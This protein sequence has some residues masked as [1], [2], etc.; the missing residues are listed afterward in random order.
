MG[1]QQLLLLVLGIV[2]VAVA[3]VGGLYIFDENIKKNNAE[4]LVS[5]AINIATAA[6]SWKIR[7][8]TFGGQRGTPR[9]NPMDFTGFT[10]KAITLDDPH[11]TIN[12]VFNVTA[13]S[14]GLVIEGYNEDFGN[15][16]TLTVDG[17]TERNIIAVISTL[18]EED[19]G[20]IDAANR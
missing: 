15:K 10:F 13:D 19:A 9:D 5:D 6:Q 2:L 20:G 3:I 8:S 4:S 14:R 16:V 17:L 18:D 11:V 7:P 1:Q 12:G